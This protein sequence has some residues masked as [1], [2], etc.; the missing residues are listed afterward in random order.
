MDER[1]GG[2]GRLLALFRLIHKGHASGFVTGRGGKLFDPDV[3]P[4]LEGRAEA[5]EPP[6]VADALRRLPAAHPRRADDRARAAD[7][8]APAAVLPHARRR[9][10]RLGLRD[11]DGLHR[12]GRRGPRARHPRRQEQPDAGVRRPRRARCGE[13]G[14][15][16]QVPEGGRATA[17]RC[18]RGVEQGGR[19][20]RPTPRRWRRRSMPSS[21]SAARPASAPVGAGTP[22]L[23]PTEERRRTGS[24]YTPRALTEPIVRHALEPAFDRLGAGRDAG[25]DPRSQGLRSGHG[26]G[27]L[28][29][30]GLP[31]SS[32]S[33]WSR[34]GRAGRRR[35]RRSRPTRTRSCTPAGWSRS[36]ASTASTRTRWR[37]ISARLSLWLATLA[38]DHEFTFLDHALKMRRQPGRA[39]RRRRSRRCTGTRRATPT[40]RRAR[41]VRERRLEAVERRAPA[42]PRGRRRCATRG[43]AAAAPAAGRRQAL[44]DPKLIGDAVIAAF[45][46]GRQAE[47][48]RG[49]RAIEGPR[50]AIE[51]AGSSWHGAGSTR[52]TAALARRRARVRPF[53]WPVEF[54]EVFDRA[55]PRLRRDR[56][57]PAVRRQEHDHRRQPAST[58]STGCRRCTRA[59]T[60][61]PTSSPTSSAAPSHLLRR[62]RLPRPDRHQHHPPGRHPRHRACGRSARRAG[63]SIDAERRIKWPGEAA[64]VISTVHIHKGP[65]AGPYRLDGREVDADHR[66]SVPRRRRR[67]S[68]AARRQR[69]QELP[70]Q[71]R[72]RHGLHLRRHRHGKGVAS[73]IAEM[74]R[75]IE[76]DPRNAERIFPYIGG[77][78]VNTSPTHAHHR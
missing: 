77:E 56:R 19:R 25:G 57:Q 40:S 4:F 49:E 66:L 55:N 23:Q 28:P 43:G 72:P 58:T 38:R 9:A 16:G 60:A 46:C 18:R 71:H 78:E 15:P 59:R 53:H 69:R 67:R 32:P 68:G 51:P 21:T 52:M 22:I 31:R 76:K 39:R 26:L 20:R 47:G 50:A 30:R 33:G 3:F 63:R 34:P 29:G 13:A 36:A 74:H 10:D 70:G 35:G 6:R 44:V 2:W 54:P 37:P 11:R 41:L 61:T 65:I 7:E 5:A 17:A 27:R 73:P 45:F 48:A 14:G 42:H 64:V 1:R 8:G 62:G 24:H 75:L 12:R